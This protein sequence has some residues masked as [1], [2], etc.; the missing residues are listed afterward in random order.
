MFTP[1]ILDLSP[2]F[3]RPME[4]TCSWHLAL[5]WKH[6][7]CLEGRLRHL[8]TK[9]QLSRQRLAVGHMPRRDRRGWLLTHR[10]V[11]RSSICKGSRGLSTRRLRTRMRPSALGVGCASISAC[12]AASGLT[13]SREL[14]RQ[15]SEGTGRTLCPGTGCS[16]CWGKLR[17]CFPAPGCFY[18]EVE[19]NRAS[20]L[21][22]VLPLFP[23]VQ[24]S[25]EA[26][27]SA[28]EPLK[29]AALLHFRNKNGV[30]SGAVV[31]CLLG[32]TAA[33]PGL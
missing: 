9:R 13:S 33:L 24:L 22:D 10:E 29:G 28:V 25:W 32:T 4:R 31:G 12:S 27:S 21:V 26:G 16:L 1:G 18:K 6:R 5:L 30:P 17:C 11:R 7:S 23:G 2:P 15:T 14:I 8:W 3:F 19:A 20:L